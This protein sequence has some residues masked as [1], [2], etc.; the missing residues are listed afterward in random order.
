MRTSNIIDGRNKRSEIYKIIPKTSSKDIINQKDK[1]EDKLYSDGLGH[2]LT[3]SDE[4]LELFNKQMIEKSEEENKQENKIRDYYLELQE[5]LKQAH[6][7][8]DAAGE[9]FESLGKCI[10][11]AMRI[12]SGDKVP[13]QDEQYLMENNM[14]LYSMA[15]NMRMIK[16]DPKEWDSLLDEDKKTMSLQDNTMDTGIDMD[17]TAETNNEGQ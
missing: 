1:P 2:Q 8:A 13:I 7:S 6:E 14:E 3:I 10:Q 15:M 5:Q 17:P 9:S 11:I 16:E 12:V 4:A